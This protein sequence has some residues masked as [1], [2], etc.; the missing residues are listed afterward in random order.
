[1]HNNHLEQILT[2]KKIDG[3]GV[4]SNAVNNA[5]KDEDDS[6]KESVI[7]ARRKESPVFSVT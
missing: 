4:E 7:M 1:M 2:E 5:T 3:K 6:D